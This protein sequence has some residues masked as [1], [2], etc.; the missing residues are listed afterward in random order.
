MEDI[1]HIS[2]YRTPQSIERCHYWRSW[3][4]FKCPFSTADISTQS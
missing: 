3:L 4:T 1:K 2:Y